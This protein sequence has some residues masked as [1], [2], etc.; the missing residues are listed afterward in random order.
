MSFLSRRRFL[1]AALLAAA[2]STGC[3]TAPAPT[4]IPGAGRVVVIGAGLAGLTAALDLKDAGWDVVVLEARDRVGGRVHTLRAPF[5][6]GLH[7]EGGGESIDD[8][9]GDIQA[10]AKRFGLP[11]EARPVDKELGGATYYKGKR[12]KTDD[13]AAQSPAVEKDYIRF[14]DAVANIAE[15]LDPAHPED[16]AQAA[17]L[18]AQSLADFIT[19]QKLDPIAEL[20]VNIEYRGEYNSDPSQISMLFVA[21]QEA[22][23]SSVPDSAAETK[24]ITGG[25]SLLPEAMAKELG[26]RVHLSSPVTRIEE[27]SDHV[28]VKAGATEIDAAFAVIAIP[29]P[30]LRNITFDP[31]LT[32]DLGD[33]VAEV[34]LGQAAKVVTQYKTRFWEPLG[35]TGFTITDLPFG[36]GWSPV[37]SYASTGGLLAQ[38]IT[39]TPAKDAAKLDDA[40]RIA[41]FQG[42]LDQV[43]PEGV[44][45]KTGN[46]ATVAW[47]NEPFTGGGYTVFRP[48]QF[49]R[50]WPAFRKGTARMRFAGEQTEVLIGYM[51]SAVRSGHRV[52][53][54]LGAPHP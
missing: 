37:D 3:S 25:N 30:P 27:G 22:A 1:G 38:F 42:Q 19:A 45:E 12:W 8:N 14:G 20:L 29:T 53:K 41:Q 50:F 33:A 9:H 7:A 34:D 40:A 51:E 35:L 31:P 32:G 43:Y 26:A 47:A 48:G 39:G 6:E 49:A 2:L 28:H 21:Q 23:T 11:L 46:A 44:A 18:D 52:A 36:I 54:E 24:R 5:T 16:F 17:S 4:S 15:G 13:F 10:M